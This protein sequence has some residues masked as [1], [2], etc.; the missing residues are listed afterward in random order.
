M[1]CHSCVCRLGQE[2]YVAIANGGLAYVC[3]TQGV[4]AAAE[5]QV[6]ET[7]RTARGDEGEQ[8]VGC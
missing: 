3:K 7:N 8:H 6:Y 5:E 2:A 4:R 1:Q